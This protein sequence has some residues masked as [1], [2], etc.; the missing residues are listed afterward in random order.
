MDNF[1]PTDKWLDGRIKLIPNVIPG[2]VPYTYASDYIRTR[3]GSAYSR[4]DVAD[5][6]RGV[7]IEFWYA[8][9]V[10]YLVNAYPVEMILVLPEIRMLLWW[11]KQTCERH[12][13]SYG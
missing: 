3:I 5:L 7:E 4:G 2:R 6:Y 9:T 12:W 10:L 13:R 11:A 1:L 8:C